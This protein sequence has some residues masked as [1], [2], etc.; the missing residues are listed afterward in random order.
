M[1]K[2][3]AVLRA[4]LVQVAFVLPAAAFAQEPASEPAQTAEAATA[5]DAASA[6]APRRGRPRRG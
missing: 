2:Q 5:T 3:S 6:T 1:L 4:L